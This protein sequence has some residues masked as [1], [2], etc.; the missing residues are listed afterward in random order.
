MKKEEFRSLIGA[1]VLPEAVRKPFRLWMTGS[2][3]VV[4]ASFCTARGVLDDERLASSMRVVRHSPFSVNETV[5]RI[6]LAVRARGQSVLARV[7][8]K[9]PV[10]VLASV[11]GGTPVVM[12]TPDSLPDVPLSLQVRRADDGG[13]DVL[14]AQLQLV[15]WEGLPTPVAEEVAA[16]PALL[17]RA[18]T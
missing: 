10:L 15:S 2:L 8:G 13:A 18:L 3:A 1:R 4:M 6:E 11:L 16:L 7:G 9:R 12:S 14:V 17:E 5:Q